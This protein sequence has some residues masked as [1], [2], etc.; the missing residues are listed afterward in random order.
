MRPYRVN[1]QGTYC[2]KNDL[3]RV[4]K[5]DHTLDYQMC[6]SSRMLNFNNKLVNRRKM[7]ITDLFL[8]KI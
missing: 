3:F 7:I 2:G 8:H 1:V 5:S 4:P 6:V